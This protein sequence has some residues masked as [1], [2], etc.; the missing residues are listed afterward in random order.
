M[1]RHRE[2]GIELMAALPW[3]VGLVSGIVAF[4]VVRYGIGWF[5]VDSSNP[6]LAGLG[7]QFA[8]GAYA[9]FAW[10]L[11]AICWVG[12]LLSIIKR[13][14]RKRLLE[15]QTGVESLRAM[16]WRQFE[17]LVGEAF[18]RQGYTVEENGLGGADGGID[19]VLRKHHAVTLVQC[20][21]WRNQ[22]VDVRVAREMYGLMTH[23]AAQAVKIVCVGDFT[24][25][26]RR[27]VE[28]KPIELIHGEALLAMIREAQ[29]TSTKQPKPSR[30]CAQTGSAKEATSSVSSKAPECPRCGALMV[31]RANRKTGDRFWGCS[32]FPACRGMRPVRDV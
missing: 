3:P 11:L 28:G 26:A 30:S 6:V 17:M 29:S 15:T 13:F 31:Q 5:L 9:A 1:A 24:A 7:R 20:K 23:H 16:T 27:F 4:V 12:A 14:H 2:G 22:R 18:R 32:T 10:A 21:Q 25:D 19:L 8:Q